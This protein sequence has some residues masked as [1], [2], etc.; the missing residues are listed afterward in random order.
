MDDETNSKA[1]TGDYPN[2]ARAPFTVRN[3]KQVLK[4]VLIIVVFA[5][6]VAG[7]LASGVLI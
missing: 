3:G 6:F 2:H 5:F 4:V 7:L 1:W